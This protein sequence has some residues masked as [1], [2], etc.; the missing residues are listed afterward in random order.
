MTS[1]RDRRPV[2]DPCHGE[3]AAAVGEL[4]VER[5]AARI[6]LSFRQP[7]ASTDLSKSVD[8]LLVAVGDLGPTTLVPSAY[9]TKT[10]SQ[11]LAVMFWMRSSSSSG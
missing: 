5:R 1:D 3:Q 9:S 6:E 4:Q 2:A 11:P 10:W 7:V 8:E